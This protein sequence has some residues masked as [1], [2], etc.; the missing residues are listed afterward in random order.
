MRPRI[1]F[2]PAALDDLRR[3]VDSLWEFSPVL[4]KRFA[5]AWDARIEQLLRFPESGRRERG[6]RRS[7]LIDPS[8]YRLIYTYSATDN[9]LRIVGLKN[10]RLR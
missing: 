8:G 2:L 3:A 4:A 1:E 9:L 10:M 5:V 7:I 6:T